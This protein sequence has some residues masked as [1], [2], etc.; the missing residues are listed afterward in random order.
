[1]AV[2]GGRISTPSGLTRDPT[3]KT[4]E[5]ATASQASLFILDLHRSGWHT[6]NQWFDGGHTF[7]MLSKNAKIIIVQTYPQGHGF[8]V[9]RSITDSNRI[10]ETLK[11]IEEYAG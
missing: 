1:M 8:N 10:D 2:T 5:K 3:V 9:Y 7:E 4:K 11:A 6:L